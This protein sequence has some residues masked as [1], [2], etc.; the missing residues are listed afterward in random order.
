MKKFSVLL[1][2]LLGAACASNPAC[3]VADVTE[4][5][6]EAPAGACEA[7]ETRCISEGKPDERDPNFVTPQICGKDATFESLAPCDLRVEVCVHGA[8]VRAPDACN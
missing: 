8:C 7:G 6:E 3:P 4:G 2:L 1:F 5:V